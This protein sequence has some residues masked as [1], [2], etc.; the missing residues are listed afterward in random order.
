MQAFILNALKQSDATLNRDRSRDL[1]IISH[2]EAY[3]HDV[4]L[5]ITNIN[6]LP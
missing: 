3:K 5:I 6:I 2:C 4:H 1:L